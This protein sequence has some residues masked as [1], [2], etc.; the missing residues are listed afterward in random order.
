MLMFHEIVTFWD[1]AEALKEIRK[2]HLLA[3]LLSRWAVHDSTDS[4]SCIIVRE[5]RIDLIV[6]ELSDW[7]DKFE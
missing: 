3:M 4:K 7:F 2:T 5:I 6:V 1:F